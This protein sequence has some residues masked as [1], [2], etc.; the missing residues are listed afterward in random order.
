MR[1]RNPQKLIMIVSLIMQLI[2]SCLVFQCTRL[3]ARTT[4]YRPSKT[5]TR[6]RI[7]LDDRFGEKESAIAHELRERNESPPSR[8]E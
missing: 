8:G 6:S 1:T 4:Q 3:S 5:H 7:I 2:M